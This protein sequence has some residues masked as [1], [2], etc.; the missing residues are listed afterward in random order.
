M[1]KETIDQYKLFTEM[2]KSQRRKND[3]YFFIIGFI[4]GGIVVCIGIMGV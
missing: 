1:N 2:Y 4:L 3:L